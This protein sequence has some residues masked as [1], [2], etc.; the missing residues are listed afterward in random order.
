MG[1]EISGPFALDLT[2]F[3]GFSVPLGPGT[4]IQ[5]GWTKSESGSLTIGGEDG[6]FPLTCGLCLLC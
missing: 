4:D 5:M 2:F 1:L 3:I 6:S